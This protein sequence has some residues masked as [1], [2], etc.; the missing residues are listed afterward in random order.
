MPYTELKPPPLPAMLASAAW[1]SVTPVTFARAPTGSPSPRCA[2]RDT[3]MGALPSGP[4][5]VPDQGS[6]VPPAAV[7]YGLSEFV[8]IDRLV[9]PS[10][11][12]AS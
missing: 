12:K 6:V 1:S 11:G 4:V 5:T 3:V 9:V 8:S 2:A 7:M 10:S